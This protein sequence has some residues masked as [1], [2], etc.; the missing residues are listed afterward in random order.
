MRPRMEG[1]VMGKELLTVAEAARAL[2]CR[3]C[4][5]R[6]EL[7]NGRLRFVDASQGIP[8]LVLQLMVCSVGDDEPP[9]LWDLWD[10]WDQ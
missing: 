2:G 5:I 9:D 4:D 7:T 10:L 1:D 3:P 8:L 6:E